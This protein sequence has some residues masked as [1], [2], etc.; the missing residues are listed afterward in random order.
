VPDS[1]IDSARTSWQCFCGGCETNHKQQ[2][3]RRR[4][5]R[6]ISRLISLQEEIAKVFRAELSMVVHYAFRDEPRR[7]GV[8]GRIIYYTH[9]ERPTHQDAPFGLGLKEEVKAQACSVDFCVGAISCTSP[10]LAWLT[11]GDSSNF[12]SVR[13]L[14]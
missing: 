14:C 1:D 8:D 12:D 6:T 2:C 13:D 9:G 10:I 11:E 7:G 4:I 5:I 3:E